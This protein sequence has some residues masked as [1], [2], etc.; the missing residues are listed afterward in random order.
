[1]ATTVHKVRL[2]LPA[3]CG[4]TIA[5][6]IE[7]S[8]GIAF[9]RTCFKSCGMQWSPGLTINVPVLITSAAEDH[10]AGATQ[11]VVENLT[12]KTLCLILIADERFLPTLAGVAP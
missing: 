9:A 1:M 5:S 2:S 10:H 8:A 6:S 12:F 7:Q 3:T 4:E 11:L